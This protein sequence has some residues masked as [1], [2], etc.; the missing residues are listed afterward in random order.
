[1]GKEK[2]TMVTIIWCVQLNNRIRVKTN[3]IKQRKRSK[4]SIK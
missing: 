2:E 1:M 4:G 3:I